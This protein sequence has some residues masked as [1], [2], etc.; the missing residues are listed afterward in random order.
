MG[1]FSKEEGFMI[2]FA[3]TSCAMDNF[4]KHQGMPTTEYIVH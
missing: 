1:M 2:S 4:A 3:N